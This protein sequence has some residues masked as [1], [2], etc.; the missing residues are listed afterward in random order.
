MK[1][2]T[3]R[4]CVHRLAQAALA[5][6]ILL[7]PTTTFAQGH[8]WR[9]GFAFGRAALQ[10]CGGDISRLCNGVVP[11]GGR[12]AQCLVDLQDKLSP[13]CRRFVRE[14]RSAQATLFAC[15]ADARQH[16]A[17]TVPGGGRVVACLNEKRT[18]ISRDCSR[19]LD[20]AAAIGR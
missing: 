14:A 13:D 18:A 16:C 2:M 19:A 15:A 8:D 7:T 12:I 17:N 3:Q 11:G 9:P 6:A 10:V 20:E 5:A 1:H 4:R